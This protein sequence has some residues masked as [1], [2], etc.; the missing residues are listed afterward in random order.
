MEIQTMGRILVGMNLRFRRFGCL[1]CHCGG[2]TRDGW[3]FWIPTAQNWTMRL[4]LSV[5]VGASLFCLSTLFI[6]NRYFQVLSTKLVPIFNS[7]SYFVQQCVGDDPNSL[8]EGHNLLQVCC[9]LKISGS[10][11][12]EC[13]LTVKLLKER[14]W[15]GS[16]RC[17]WW[18]ANLGYG[19]C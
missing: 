1:F 17:V 19:L 18:G 11:L 4:W 12:V 5:H 13:L 6:I 7:F 8:W 16:Y 9:I 15:L 10:E 3:C 2:G 14:C